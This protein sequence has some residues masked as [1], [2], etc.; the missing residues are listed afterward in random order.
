MKAIHCVTILLGLSALPA[1]ADLCTNVAPATYSQLV[2]LGATGCQ[3]GDLTFSNFAFASSATGTGT[4]PTANQM[5]FI[6]DGPTTATSTGQEVW[7]FEFDPNL[8]VLGIGTED[9]L[10]EYDITAPTAEITTDHLLEN[11][12]AIGAATGVVAEGPDCGK[13]TLGGPCAFL[14]TLSVTPSSPHQ[15][16]LGI[17][18]YISLHVIT[19]MSVI[20]DSASGLAIISDVRNA[21]DPVPEPA[22][23]PVMLGAGLVL[24][25]FLRRSQRKN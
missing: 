4:T 15:D 18:P 2:S 5:S 8:A 16:I 1:M 17:G 11:V 6:I 24:V 25:G 9:I 20:S 21:V 13:T 12:L 10:I 14:P 19:D 22:T 3:L 7:G 23:L